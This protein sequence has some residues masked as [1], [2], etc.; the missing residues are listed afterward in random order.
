MPHTHEHHDHQHGPDCGHKG[1]QHGDHVDYL[2][3]GH[4]HH[5]TA[6]GV[7]EEHVLPVTVANPDAC[8]GGIAAAA[9][10]RRMST[11]RIVVMPLCLTAIMSTT[12][13]M[14][15]SI[16]HTTGIATITAK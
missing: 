6:A 3:D 12:S 2:H 14:A 7:V 10:T 1:I 11:G 9:M 16:T 4:L 5:P 15:T 13:S 8:S